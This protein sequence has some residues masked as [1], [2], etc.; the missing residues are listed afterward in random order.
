MGCVK[1]EGAGDGAAAGMGRGYAEGGVEFYTKVLQ[2]NVALRELMGSEGEGV[3][4]V[5]G[6]DEVSGDGK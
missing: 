2:R 6:N 1:R 5:K 4:T 3:F